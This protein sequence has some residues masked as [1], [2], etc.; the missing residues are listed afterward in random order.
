[1]RVG[2]CWWPLTMR[3]NSFALSCQSS[4]WPWPRAGRGEQSVCLGESFRF[5][6]ASELSFDFQFKTLATRIC[7][8]E[9]KVQKRPQQSI[10]SKERT[11]LKI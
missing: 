11:E 10:R 3:Q 2:S 4:T 6:L 9:N 8:Q 7:S 5:V 1:M